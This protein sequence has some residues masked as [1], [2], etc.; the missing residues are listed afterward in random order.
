VFKR[1]NFLVFAVMLALAVAPLAFWWSA[2]S[3]HRRRLQDIQEAAQREAS[4]RE[5]IRHLRYRSDVADVY[6]RHSVLYLRQGE[7][8]Q[9]ARARVQDEKRRELQ[10]VYAKYGVKPPPDLPE[11][12]VPPL[13]ER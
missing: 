13:P 10:A 6:A 12:A 1:S 3:R 8:L 11:G 9:E 4:R 5:E 2:D 7:T